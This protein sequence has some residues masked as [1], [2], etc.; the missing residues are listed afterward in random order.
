[1]PQVVWFWKY[2]IKI[3][4]FKTNYAESSVKWRPTDGLLD[5][6]PGRKQKE[7]YWSCKDSWNSKW[8]LQ[9]VMLFTFTPFPS[10]EITLAERG[11]TQ[12]TIISYWH[13]FVC[14][15]QFHIYS[16]NSVHIITFSLTDFSMSSV[17]SKKEKVGQ[18]KRKS[19]RQILKNIFG[20]QIKL[21]ISAIN[22]SFQDPFPGS[23]FFPGVL[24]P[25]KAIMLYMKIKSKYW[26]L[27]H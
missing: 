7:N 24:S 8:R 2:D 5:I 27:C 13:S 20:K 9:N 14:V 15:T 4:Y 25:S 11:W 16:W 23:T 6:L 1:M 3:L 19:P 17:T 18:S 21:L 22:H 26:S 10:S 12:G